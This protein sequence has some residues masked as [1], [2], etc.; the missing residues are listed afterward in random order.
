MPICEAVFLERRPVRSGNTPRISLT[1]WC[2]DCIAILLQS[3][4]QGRDGTG[5][6]SD[7]TIHFITEGRE[8]HLSVTSDLWGFVL[9]THFHSKIYDRRYLYVQK[10]TFFK[11]VHTVFLFSLSRKTLLVIF[12]HCFIS[13]T[14]TNSPS[15]SEQ[16]SL[17]KTFQPHSQVLFWFCCF[18]LTLSPEILVFCGVVLCV[19]IWST[20]CKSHLNYMILFGIIYV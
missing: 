6:V 3:C 19:H 13:N 12:F 7:S 8:I 2:I 10:H 18:S 9:I 4:T 14:G 17:L 15:E 5:R 20:L 1:L 11:N 16:L